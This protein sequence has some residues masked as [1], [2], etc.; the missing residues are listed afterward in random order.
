VK[1]VDASPFAPANIQGIAKPL[2]VALALVLVA[3]AWL[4]TLQTDITAGDASLTDPSGLVGPLMDD[5]GEFVVAWHTWGVTHPPGYPLQNLLGNLVAQSYAWL[6][7]PPAAAAS[8]VSFGF[9]LTALVLVAALVWPWDG[10]GPA[11]AAALLLPA[12]GGLVWLYASVAEVYALGLCLALGALA[13]ALA[14]GAR[15]ERRWPILALGL[16]Y[17]LAL[18]HH[19]T[20]LALVPALVLAAWPARRQGKAWLLA[21]GL[22]PL[23]LAVYA[24]LPLAAAAGSPWIYGRSPATLDGFLDAVL[25]REYS[26]QLSPP[27]A[28]GAIGGALVER[29]AFLAREMTPAGLALGLM[30]LVLGCLRPATRRPAA[31]LGLAVGGYVFAPVGQYLLIGTHLLIM[32]A[33]A[34]LAAAWGLGLAAWT[35]RRPGLAWAGLSLTVLVAAGAYRAHVADIRT[36]TQDLAGRRLIDAVATVARDALPE[37]RGSDTAPIVVEAWSPRYF[38]LAYGKWVTGELADVRL[39]DARADLSGLS[40]TGPLPEVSYTTPDML[41]L[42]PIERWWDLAGTRALES[43]GDGLI[44]LR[45]APRFGESA[46]IALD[47][48]DPPPVR[49]GPVPSE[50]ASEADVALVEARAWWTE[51]GDIRLTTEWRALRQPTRDYHVFVHATDQPAIRGPE[52]ILAQGDRAHP[53]YGFYPSSR[54]RAGERV[55]DDYR[56]ALPMDL[57]AGRRPTRLDVGLY[58]VGVDG[59]F[60]DALRRSVEIGAAD[61]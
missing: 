58:T 61:R 6:G 24:Y 52:D 3:L 21:A 55:R 2:I 18:G 20:L 11:T 54:W 27:S 4:A 41:Y 43:S 57:P 48:G 15:P 25:T 47:G 31:V 45:Q 29:L 12:F 34:V 46:E 38:A 22:A 23:S 16:V 32:V 26:A 56:I 1:V 36:Y 9:A 10:R 35:G 59:A 33:S 28:P 5:S 39:I 60:A 51:D 50:S 7:V 13:L 53:V 37:A 42:A 30:G 8:L 14:A 17:G 19:R 44:A 40:A 49:N